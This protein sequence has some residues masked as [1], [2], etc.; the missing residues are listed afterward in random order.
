MNETDIRKQYASK[1]NDYKILVVDILLKI[2]VLEDKKNARQIVLRENEKDLM[3]L[4]SLKSDFEKSKTTLE[5]AQRRRNELQIALS[6]NEVGRLIEGIKDSIRDAK[7]EEARKQSDVDDYEKQFRNIRKAAASVEGCAALLRN[8]TQGLSSKEEIVNA[9]GTLISLLSARRM[10]AYDENAAFKNIKDTLS[11]KLQELEER[12]ET[13]SKNQ[14]VY[15]KYTTM[16]LKAINEE[17]RS[18]KIPTEARIFADLLE[19]H[20][21]EW[22]DAIEGYLNTQRTNIIVEPQYY[23]I[24]AEVY[25]RMK[26]R[27][28]S[29][30]IVNTTKI[31][32]DSETVPNSLFDAVS[33]DNRY[34]RA[35]AAYLL[36]R[37]TRCES[38]GELK[39]YRIAITR[40]CM[41]YQGH[42]LSK[43][44]PE[45]YSTPFIGREAIR[46]QL[47]NARKEQELLEVQL[48]NT[49]ESIRANNTILEQ[50]NACSFDTFRNKL[51]APEEL[52]KIR[53][54]IQ[55]EEAELKEA[56]KD[57][58]LIELNMKLV[59]AEVAQETAQKER[60]NLNSRL[61]NKKRDI[62]ENGKTELRLRGEIEDAEKEKDAIAGKSLRAYQEALERYQESIRSKTAA[63]TAE[64]YGPRRTALVNQKTNALQALS[65]L[66]SQYKSGDFGTGMDVIQ[67]Y[68][69]DLEKLEKSDLLKYEDRLAKAQSDCELE[70]RENFLVKMRE[71]IDHAANLFTKL[72]R[73]LKG[74]YYGN[75]SYQFELGPN[76]NRES[77]YNM[78]TSN[79]NLG[80]GTLFSSLFNEQYHAEMEDLFSQLTDENLRGTSVMEELTDYRSYLDY[81]IWVNSKDGK[82]Q[83]F[84]K[85][86]G[87]KSGG[88]TQTPYYV[89]IAASFAQLYSGRETAR[90]IILDEAFNNMDEDRIESMMKFLKS[91][92]FQII[93][94]APPSR[95]EVIGEYVDSIYLA[96]RMNNTSIVE[97]YFL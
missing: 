89:A 31:S 80:E 32:E 77:L 17:F 83:R 73:S 6:N 55:D 30:G 65:A 49:E 93:L 60:D 78:I 48:K 85:T 34:A 39:R 88:E 42:V 76:P 68:R 87:E 26:N 35:Y 3:L 92:N 74:V 84:S 90:I 20:N 18:R 23:D 61:E 51:F 52:K 47:E 21:P 37:V 14:P 15:D 53:R 66:Q 41:K 43:I 13:L 9:A 2:A 63:K 67:E 27:I 75:D 8:L 97:E 91:Q 81:E 70:F 36:G 22:R 64:N 1:E 28:H 96:V 16:L 11:K 5:D 7:T 19:I 86:Y 57:P 94:A 38:V 29:A 56:Q 69:D 79:I 46:I 40:E 33:S 24:A 45:I 72:N 54:K 82:R 25:D 58:T 12:I 71:N 50:I 59:A 44:N 95:M 62:Q 4:E 10:A